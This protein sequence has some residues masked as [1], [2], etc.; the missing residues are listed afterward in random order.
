MSPGT[1]TA[2]AVSKAKGVSNS[3]M[4]AVR[5]NPKKSMAIGA[6]AYG[7]MS[8][9]GRRRGSGSPSTRRAGGIYK[10]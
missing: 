3:V 8:L 6:A 10:Y 7:G 5:A 4:R 2:A 1:S 9:I